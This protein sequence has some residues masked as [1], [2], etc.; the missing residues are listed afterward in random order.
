MRKFLLLNFFLLLLFSI[1]AVGQV[2][3]ITGR[4][5]G[6]AGK[7]L[8]D[9]TVQVKGTAVVTTTNANGEFSIRAASNQSLIF[10]YVNYTS[11]EFAVGSRSTIDV[12][13]SL[14]QKDIEEVVVVAMDQKK[15]PRELGFSVQKA[16]GEELQ[17]TQRESFV[18]ALQ[19]RIAGVTVN[20]T[21]G[22]AGASSQIVLRGFNSLSLDNSPLFV[23]DG[24]V[25]DNQSLSEGG[26]G[27]SLGLAGDPPS[28]NRVND[29]TNRI[30]D[31]NPND[32]ES[33]TVLK[34]PEATALYGSQASSGA[35]IITTKKSKGNG[36]LEVNYDNSFRASFNTRMP[37]TMNAYQGGS[38]NIPLAQFTSFGPRYP[39]GT[40]L[41]NNIDNFFQTNFSQT[42]NLA[43]SFGSK[44][45]SF[46]VSGSFLNSNSAVPDNKYNRYNV[47]V[48][49]STKIGKFL[50]IDPAISY[51]KTEND[52]PIR[53]ASGYMMSLLTWPAFNDI[54]VWEDDNGLKIPLF[55]SNPNADFDNPFYSV[56][57]NRSSDQTDRILATLGIDITPFDWLTI[58]GR[59]GYDTYAQD[60]YTRYDSMSFS[61]ARSQ[62]G[63]LTNYYRDF[64][65]YNHTITATAKK[66]FGKF[67]G[68][69]M[70]G[71]MW[72]DYETQQWS[73]TGTNL[74]DANGTDSSITD[75]ATRV[76]LNNNTLKGLPNYSIRRSAAYFG[77]ASIGYDNKVFLTYS[78]RFEE[79]SIFPKD[80]R[81]YNYPAGSLSIIM[82]DLVPGIKSSA[83]NYWK[84]RGS[85][86]N[87]ARSSSPYANQSVFNI[88][89]GSGG[90]YYYGFTNSNPLLSPEEQQTFELGSEFRLFKNRINLDATYYNTTNKN[91]IVENFRASYGTGFVLNTLNVG[92]N[93]NEGVEVSLSMDLIK[94]K[95]FSWNTKFN[96]NKMWNEVLELP[97][98]VPEF[99]IADTWLY[100]NARGGL[101]KGGATTTITAYGYK[102]NNAGQILIN[103]TTGLPVIDANFKVRGDRNPDFTMGWV[104]TLNI[105]SRIR[106]SFLWDLKV[107]GDIFNATDDFLTG[108]GRSWRTYDR[109]TPR[110]ID[111]VLEDGL[112]NTNTP[113]K[114]TIAITPAYNNSYYTTMPEEEFIERDVNWFR[115]RDV[116]LYYNFGKNVQKQLRFVKSLSAFVT[117]TDPILISNYS[118]ADPQSS[119]LSAGS[120]G[121]GGFGFDYGNIGAPL[122]FNFGLKANF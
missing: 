122:G 9:V 72:Q 49:N 77:E 88:N 37:R 26:G 70:I 12:S 59:F 66:Q 81:S 109:Y 106:L 116:S 1:T 40:K 46:R 91:L 85:L 30:A 47:R 8:R 87:T 94:N 96:F 16:D 38:N 121:V 63:Q 28:A 29:Y 5:T 69:L 35:I 53:G 19:G 115:L 105:G 13:L 39:W 92:S 23:I 98:N 108:Y 22:L 41:Y 71:N 80:F 31:I 78:H 36:K 112:E 74:S 6:D 56:Y 61:L 43:L 68:R 97:S 27:A 107:G 67:S 2:K 24:V 99:Y 17:Q 20:Q 102:R 25:A 75:P 103:A 64:Y 3:V 58:S 89:T 57:K 54:R 76:R 119:G 120:R 52:K 15:N 48:S 7:P 45:S 90:G 60:G 62:K 83:L 34:G 93:R 18:T 104:N 50:K 117:V 113:P 73:V 114:N 100:G 84:L 118:G 42:H 101:V 32:I 79:S 65:G 14:N 21:A 82:S 86:A 10:T 11:R 44:V 110:V 33:I 95:N 55:S 4:V 51:I 111:G